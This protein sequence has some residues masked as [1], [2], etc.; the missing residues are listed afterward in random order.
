MKIMNEKNNSDDNDNNMS[1]QSMKKI[2]SLIA[3][4]MNY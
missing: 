2:C 3:L 4:A 1:T